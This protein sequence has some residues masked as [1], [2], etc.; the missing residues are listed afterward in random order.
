MRILVC[1]HDT[2]ATKTVAE[3]LLG[4]GFEPVVMSSG[5]DAWRALDRDDP[6]PVL[7]IGWDTPGLSGLEVCRML[8]ST[9][10]GANVYVIALVESKATGDLI[11][12]REAGIDDVLVKPVIGRE[13]RFRIAR[14]L[15]FREGR[16]RPRMASL[17][18]GSVTPSSIPPPMGSPMASPE[19]R[20]PRASE[21]TIT[22]GG[23]YRLERLIAEGPRSTVWLALHLSLGINVA[24]R[25]MKADAAELAD[26]SSFEADARA[27]AQLRSSHVAR[28]YGH[29]SHEGLPYLAMEYLAGET[30]ADRV[31]RRGPLTMAETGAL[32]HQLVD[33]LGEVH[34]AGLVH[35]N[36]KPE[37]VVLLPAADHSAGFVA[38]L[39]DFGFVQRALSPNASGAVTT[40]NAAT[41]SPECLRGDVTPNKA[42]DLWALG[43]TIFTAATAARPFNGD[44]LAQIFARVCLEALPVPSQ[45]HSGL[46]PEFDAWFAKACARDPHVRFRSLPEMV[47]AMGP[48]S[49]APAAGA[50]ARA[51]TGPPRPTPR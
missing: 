4:W 44:T 9:P 27:A 50:G 45:L 33:A 42:L 12:G 41:T 32:V 19:L 23:R 3:H 35:G 17:P 21:P 46:P 30:L 15:A 1:D 37:N 49:R 25:F 5:V 18:P 43:A 28:I 47:E 20:G 39:V 7:L 31:A 22:L 6:P 11:E 40:G 13:L 48:T 14:G 29:G 16:P 34:G 10:Q 8:R 26:Y 24:I 2:A 36:V 38:K 51:K